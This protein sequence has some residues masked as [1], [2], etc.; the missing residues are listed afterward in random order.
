MLN[1]L[2]VCTGNVCR[3]PVA[4]QLLATRLG[5]L[6]V[7]FQSAG[8]RA[9]NGMSMTSGAMALATNRGVDPAT[10]LA[11]RARLLADSH[12]RGTDLLLGMAREHRREIVELAP[13]S[14]RRT[15]TIRELARLCEAITDDDLRGAWS[16]AERSNEP[17]VRLEFML[18]LIAAQRG[19]APEPVTVLDDDVVDPYGRS[20]EF[21]ERSGLELEPGLQ[22]VERIV[23]LTFE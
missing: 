18:R 12:L 23:R 14:M 15:F 4:A 8:T 5:D 10:T 19:V 6:D 22:T 9:R 3:S 2:T 1:I 16:Q 21:Y 13:S 20:P 7:E 17:G 11:H